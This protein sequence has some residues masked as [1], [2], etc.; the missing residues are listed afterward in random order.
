MKH[1][2][3]HA[4]T[5]VAVEHAIGRTIINTPLGLTQNAFAPP[6][7]YGILNFYQTIAIRMV[8]AINSCF[9]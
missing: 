3:V 7:R 4:R 1:N 9:I 6:E 8:G 2:K 5:R